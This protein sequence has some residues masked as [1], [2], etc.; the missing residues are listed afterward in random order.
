M[1][2]PPEKLSGD[3]LRSVLESYIARDGT[4][5][6]EVECSLPEKVAQLHDQVKKN[7]VLIV[8]DE[9][10]ETLNLLTRDEYQQANSGK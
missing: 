3:L 6:G 7:A 5:Y 10:E 2:I 9:R 4:D 1:I 8:Y